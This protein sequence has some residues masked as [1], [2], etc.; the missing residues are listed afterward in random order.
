MSIDIN[1]KKAIMTKILILETNLKFS[2][3]EKKMIKRRRM[4][5]KS[6]ING[7]NMRKRPSG[8]GLWLWFKKIHL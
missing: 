2:L 8:L 1:M 3:T 5:G 6:M 7:L 4:V